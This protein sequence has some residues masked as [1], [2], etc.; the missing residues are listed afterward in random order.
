[1]TGPY[2]HSMALAQAF[3]FDGTMRQKDI[4]GEWVPLDEPGPLS[5]VISGNEKWVRGIRFEEIDQNLIL[6]HVTSK[7]DKLL[8]ID[9]KQCPMVMKELA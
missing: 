4:I 3:Q 9:L 6:R 5:D 2:R 8:T 1:M 7:R